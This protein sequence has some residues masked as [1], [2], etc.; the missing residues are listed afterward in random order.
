MNDGGSLDLLPGFAWA[1]PTAFAAAVV[2]FRFE[3]GDVLFRSA[4]GYAVQAGRLPE[5]LIGVQ[6][7]QPPRST[8]ALA[9]EFDGGRRL[10]HWRSEV[11]LDRIELASGALTAHT[12]TQGRLFTTL[13]RGTDAAFEAGSDE[14]PL[15]RSA[16]ELAQVLR[17]GSVALP[18]DRADGPAGNRFAFV[19]DLASDVSRAKA[20]AIAGA[21]AGLG[22]IRLRD[23]SPGELEVAGAA[24]YQPTLVVRSIVLRGV[25]AAA[26]EAALA[27]V[28]YA[29]SGEGERFSLARHGLLEVFEAS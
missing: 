12:T 1:V 6:I 19:V 10:A 24:D 29:G 22:P 17:D 3:Q 4:K 2:D 20:A 14:P 28:L 18:A 11:E 8:R 26:I 7:R 27:R 13:W 23:A 15:P 5:D 21:L 9:N 25:T 16:R